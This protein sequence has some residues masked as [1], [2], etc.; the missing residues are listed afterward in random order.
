MIQALSIS[1]VDLK[2]RP[3][4]HALELGFD[5][6]DNGAREAF[7]CLCDLCLKQHLVDGAEGVVGIPHE[8]VRSA[9]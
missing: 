9:P 5:A 2:R 4:Q 1:I 6:R 7:D 3:Q 8:D